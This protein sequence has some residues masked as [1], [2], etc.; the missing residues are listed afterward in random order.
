MGA[1]TRDESGATA[2]LVGL[3]AI[4]LFGAA[5]LAVDI[6][7][8]TME[9]QRLHDHVDS[10]AHAGAYELPGDGE[11]AV[12]AAMEMALAQDPTM[13]PSVQLFCVVASVGAG[14]RVA[15]GQIPATCDP[16]VYDGASVRCNQEIC[17]IPCSPSARCNTM[18][19]V[20]AKT[21]DYDFAPV[22]GEEEG[23]TGSVSSSAC[24]GSCGETLPN[25]MDIVI[26]ADRTTSMADPDREMMK[27][28]IVDSLGAMDPALHY[29][30]FGTLHKSRSA[31]GCSTS[32]ST[33]SDSVTGGTWMPVPFSNDYKADRDAGINPSSALVRGVGCMPN[34]AVPGLSTGSYGTHP[35]SG[36]KAAARYL[37]DLDPN[38]LSSLPARPGTPEKVL[39]FETDGQPDELL[40]SGSTSISRSGDVGAG[41]NSYGNGN[42][43][44]GCDNMAQV[45]E[46]A[47]DRGVTVLVIGFGDANSAGCEKAVP[48]RGQVRRAPWVRDYLAGAAS[49][50]PN[51]G[52]SRADSDCSTTAERQ[53]ENGDGDYYFCAATGSELGP[54]FASA[55]NT[56]TES[57]RLIKLP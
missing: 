29:V 7:S 42:G 11:A 4:V 13:T 35:A 18:R 56:V 31:S 9:R 17:A 20:D 2:V 10:A 45:A 26:M 32:A 25:P 46:Q 3:L 55:V 22:I 5:A 40:E 24:K 14:R 51:G 38:N 16:G 30:A 34:G 54:I 33:A 15:P 41:R 39:I 27:S 53:V 57:I 21:V 8:L 19:V 48:S 12:E 28:A 52:P 23:S 37:L 47:K 49:P 50:S 36:M 43:R 1:R 6:A 44:R